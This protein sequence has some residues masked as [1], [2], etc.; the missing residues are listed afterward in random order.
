MPTHAAFLRGVNLGAHRKVSSAELRTVFEGAG[1][2]DVATFRTSGNVAFGAGREPETKLKGRIEAALAEALGWEVTVFVRTAGEVQAI[3]ATEPFTAKDVEATEGRLQ[4]IMLAG[5]PAAAAR[6]QM[7]ATA[8][9]SDRLALEGR[10]LYW[11]PAAGT[12]NAEW[13]VKTA[14][15]LFGPTTMRTMGTVEL[16]A[17]KF[18]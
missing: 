3:A 15:R 16:L 12:Q 10:E 8:T 17:R 11:L 7:L 5:K 2:A 13:E 4:V 14:D 9:E 18:F 6:K 1:L